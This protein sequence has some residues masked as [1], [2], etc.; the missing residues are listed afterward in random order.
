MKVYYHAGLKE[1]T[2]SSGYSV[3]TLKEHTTCHASLAGTVLTNA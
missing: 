2:M 1:L 3:Q